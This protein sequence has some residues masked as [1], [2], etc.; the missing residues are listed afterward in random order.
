[1]TGQSLYYP[2]VMMRAL[3]Q[4][5][6]EEY[7]EYG[8][9]V[10]NVVI[11]GDRIT[12]AGPDVPVPVGAEIIDASGMHLLPGL[13]DCHCHVILTEMD[14]SHLEAMPATLMTAEASRIM[15]EVIRPAMDLARSADMPVCHVESDW[16]DGQYREIKAPRSVIHARPKRG[17][18]LLVLP[19]KTINIGVITWLS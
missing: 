18:V 6:T 2:R 10:A 17:L 16:M 9:H 13:I 3:A 5:L 15:G 1:M 19:D 14:L 7:S 8:V 12:A 11:D 4:V